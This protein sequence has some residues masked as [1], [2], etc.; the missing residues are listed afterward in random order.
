LAEPLF[1]NWL[2]LT[3]GPKF[4]VLREVSHKN[5]KNIPAMEKFKFRLRRIWIGYSKLKN[6]I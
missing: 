4:F 3:N 6:G 2:S 5:G 1:H